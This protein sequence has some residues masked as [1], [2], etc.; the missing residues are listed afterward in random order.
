M[1]TRH[2]K[3]FFIF[4]INC[5]LLTGTL[6]LQTKKYDNQDTYPLSPTIVITGIGSLPLPSISTHT[7][8]PERIIE[9]VFVMYFSTGRENIPTLVFL[10]NIKTEHYNQCLLINPFYN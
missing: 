3:L 1:T 7:E 10:Q 9:N 2:L 8:P 6:L 5:V 4:C